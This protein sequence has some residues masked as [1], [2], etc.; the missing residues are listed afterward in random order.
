MIT[1]YQQKQLTKATENATSTRF[2]S[3]CNM[4]RNG[5]GGTWK[6]IQGGLRRRW[7]CEEC[8]IVQKQKA[9]RKD[10]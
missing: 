9:A 10:A 2:C 6:I 5:Q 8:T 3:N 7:K 4:T 1:P